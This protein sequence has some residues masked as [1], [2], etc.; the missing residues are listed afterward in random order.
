MHTQALLREALRERVRMNGLTNSIYGLCRRGDAIA[1]CD[2]RIEVI[3]YFL[4]CSLNGTET[5]GKNITLLLGS[6]EMSTTY[7]EKVTKL[8]D[9]FPHVSILDADSLTLE[10]I[11][12]AATIS[13]LIDASAGF[14]DNNFYNYEVQRTL[15][16]NL[17]AHDKFSSVF[18]DKQRKNCNKCT[19][20]MDHFPSVWK[21]ERD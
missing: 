12:E 13:G 11:K 8:Q 4:K 18:L 7:R 21:K 5:Q 1:E 6:D 14:E 16:R 3:D 10:V 17:F 15:K 20:L 19:R 9:G 2:T